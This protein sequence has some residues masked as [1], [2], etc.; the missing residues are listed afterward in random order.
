MKIWFSAILIT[1][2]LLFFNNAEAA[3]FPVN[4]SKHLETCRS[5]V[6]EMEKK[7]RI[8]KRLLNAISQA[9]TG[10][11]HKKT[12]EII[13]WPWTVYSEGRGRY[14][15]TKEAAIKEV[16]K[17]KAKG[18][19]NI[20]VGCMQVNLHYH[21]DAF[22][23]LQAAFDPETNAEYA[24]SLLKSLRNDNRS[25][26]TAVAHYHSKTRKYFVPYKKKVLK[27]WRDAQK[28][29]TQAR[30]AKI[31]EQY[32][33]KRAAQKLIWEKVKE[34]RKNKARTQAARGSLWPKTG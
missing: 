9:E 16:Q 30:M 1:G 6:A 25:W 29:D 26:N 19:R 2:V 5:A 21:P 34:R 18:V 10:R 12:R 14:L 28:K 24:A 3:T 23:N 8:P 20:D 32:K 33:K 31:R 17:L 22:E 15:P 4:A 7:Y 27:L 13:A 11:W